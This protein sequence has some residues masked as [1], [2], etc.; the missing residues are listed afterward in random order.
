MAIDTSKK[1]TNFKRIRE[2]FFLVFFFSNI[3]VLGRIQINSVSK[4]EMFKSH[5]ALQRSWPCCKKEINICQHFFAKSKKII[6]VQISS[7]LKIT[8]KKLR[9]LFIFWSFRIASHSWH[10]VVQLHYWK[11]EEG[12][13]FCTHTKTAKAPILLHKSYF[14]CSAFLISRKKYSLFDDYGVRIFLTVLIV[15]AKRK[16]RNIVS[17]WIK[18]HIQQHRKVFHRN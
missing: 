3:M 6:L 12:I 7:C 1:N 16:Y 14:K 13:T 2:I 9:T 4:K 11:F 15:S 5:C 17:P 10:G 8:G 18:V